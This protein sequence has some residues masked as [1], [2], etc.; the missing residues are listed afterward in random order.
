[1]GYESLPKN[2]S[3]LPLGTGSF[4]KHWLLV[5]RIVY[6]APLYDCDD[7]LS[8]RWNNDVDVYKAPELC[9]FLGTL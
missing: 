5:T 7:I 9:A 8:I 6:R 3:V 4:A 2:D 1:M